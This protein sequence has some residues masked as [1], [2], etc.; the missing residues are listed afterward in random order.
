M[1]NRRYTENEFR[2]AVADPDVRTIADLCRALGIVPRGGNYE[3]VRAFAAELGI[4]L[5]A[6]LAETARRED[7]GGQAQSW[8]DVSDEDIAAAV[9]D[10]PSL[11]AA[12][13]SLGFVP[14]SAG[15]RR[16]RKAI[17]RTGADTSHL[18]GQGWARGRTFPGRRRKPTAEYFVRGKLRHTMA[19]KER[20]LA[21]GL[22]ERHCE[23]CGRS[24]WQGEAI[25]LELDHVDGDRW[26][27]TLENLRLLCP[28]CHALTPTY[29]GR[30]IG[31]GRTPGL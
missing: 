4:D 29:R 16:L 8:N 14:S 31:N 15:Y 3:S 11:A 5:R 1:R 17:D 9:S 6:H 2:T 23:R 28:N 24:E 12:M 19:L 13:R 7:L 10:Q 25:P 20:L 27:N 18:L 26:N 30:N 22:R 21:D